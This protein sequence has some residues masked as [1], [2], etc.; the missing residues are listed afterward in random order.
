VTCSRFSYESPF[1]RKYSKRLSRSA[2]FARRLRQY[3]FLEATCASRIQLASRG[4]S[5]WHGRRVLTEQSVK[6]ECYRVFIISTAPAMA[7]RTIRVHVSCRRVVTWYVLTLSVRWL[8]IWA[9]LQ[10]D[11]CLCV[12]KI[13]YC[14]GLCAIWHRVDCIYIPVEGRFWRWKLQAPPKWLYINYQ[15]D[16]L[17]IIYS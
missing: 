9:Y 6:S 8:E 12:I 11:K 14:Y 17:I 1:F 15:L 5:P 13:A 10:P 7:V 16:A 3:I 4:V 2:S